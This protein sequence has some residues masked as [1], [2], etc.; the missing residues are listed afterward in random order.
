MYNGCGKHAQISFRNQLRKHCP[1]LSS[2]MRGQA[3]LLKVFFL[4][5]SLLPFISC[6]LDGAGDGKEQLCRSWQS[7]IPQKQQ[8][9]DIQMRQTFLSIMREARSLLESLRF[10]LYQHWTTVFWEAGVWLHRQRAMVERWLSA[11]RLSSNALSVSRWKRKKS[12]CCVCRGHAMPQY[13]NV[14]DLVSN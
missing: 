6:S 7:S 1:R 5:Y 8:D 2:E 13:R 11:A 10:A 14:E 4:R 3:R 9:R 12:N